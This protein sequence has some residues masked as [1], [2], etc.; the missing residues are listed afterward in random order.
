MSNWARDASVVVI[1]LVIVVLAG[2]TGF[3]A[4]R[5]VAIPE[6]VGSATLVSAGALAG[7]AK[8]STGPPG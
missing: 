1:G 2:L 7:V 3:L 4:W 5:E 8:G 6:F